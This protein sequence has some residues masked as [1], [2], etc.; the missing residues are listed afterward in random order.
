MMQSWYRSGAA[1]LSEIQ[2]TCLGEDALALWFLGQCGYVLKYRSTTILIDPVLNDLTAPDGSSRRHYPAPFAP[3]ALEPD[4][5][6]CTHAH[7][8]HMAPPTLRAIARRYPKAKFLL[9]EGCAALGADLGMQELLTMLPGQMRV[10]TD[11]LSVTALSAAH[12]V[13]IR[14]KGNPAMALGYCL[15]LGDIRLVHLGDTYLTEELL[16]D[17]DSMEPPHVFLVPINGSDRFRDMRSCIGN[18]EA[19]EAAKLAARLGADLTMPTHFDMVFDNTVDPLRFA[20][21]LRRIRP[22][23]K[24]HIPALGERIVYFGH[25]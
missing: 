16:H 17:L 5:V 9:P 4:F 7:A 22:S 6:L 3:D 13:H 1:L 12:P 24:W 8:D 21:E 10:L 14:E 11:A 2:G 25:L 23:A 18:M 19:E 15:T 20:A